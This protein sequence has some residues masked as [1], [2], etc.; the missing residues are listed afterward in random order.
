MTST[1]KHLLTLAVVG[2][3]LGVPTA[4][5]AATFCVGTADCPGGTAKNELQPALDAARDNPATFDTILLAANGPGYI[6]PF[7][8][9]VPT[10]AGP[11]T[12]RAPQFA[13]KAVGTKRPVITAFNDSTA[14]TVDRARI[15]G[16]DIVAD[17]GNTTALSITDSELEDVVVRAPFRDASGL[18]IKADGFVTL[19]DSAVTDGSALALRVVQDAVVRGRG[20]RTANGGI[21]VQSLNGS[22]L[23]LDASRIDARLVGLSGSG[24]TTL[25]RSTVTT[26]EQ[27]GGIQQLN[28]ALLLDHVTVV[29]MGAR[30]PQ[31]AVDIGAFERGEAFLRSVTSSGYARGLT[32]KQ[33]SDEPFAVTVT[34]SVWRR[35]DD[36]LGDGPFTFSGGADAEPEFADLAGGDLRP[37]PGSPQIDTD[38][39]TARDYV[40]VAGAPANDGDSDGEAR[41]DAGAFELAAGDVPARIVPPVLPA[42]DTKAPAVAPVLPV[43]TIRAATPVLDRRAPKLSGVR[44]TK[45]LKLTFR[46]DE[47][48]TV[49]I[50]SGKVTIVRK[51]KAGKRSLALGRVLRSKGLLRGT[52]VRIRVTATDAAQ[53]TT[54]GK[55]LRRTLRRG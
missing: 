38:R 44:L 40:D 53:N 27:G 26:S 22:T 23:D 33:F 15:E 18:G 31:A 34:D 13:I 37:N 39:Q 25:T 28:G 41:A 16:V 21:G 12:R 14:L 43:A 6:G 9:D 4:A 3:A 10:P 5:G 50:R 55:S 42:A 32:R 19:N 24:R 52:R 51:V 45:G 35:G 17:E 47:A 46:I 8:Y 1:K 20:F 30:S 36:R 29:N 54:A 49:R 11:V 48:A 2:G 7:T